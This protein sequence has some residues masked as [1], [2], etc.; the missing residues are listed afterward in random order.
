M[1]MQ[2]EEHIHTHLYTSNGL[3]QNQS[4]CLFLAHLR[5]HMELGARESQ[6]DSL[7]PEEN[8]FLGKIILIRFK[9]IHEILVIMKMADFDF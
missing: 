2:G 1:H 3:L 4:D 7:Q 6:V 5:K 9:M 8:G